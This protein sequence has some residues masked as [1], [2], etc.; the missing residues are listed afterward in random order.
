MKTTNAWFTLVE[1][2]VVLTIIFI[3]V[4]MTFANYNHYQNIAK[5]KFAAKEVSLSISESRNTAI[6][7]YQKENINQKIWVYF[8][9]GSSIIEYFSVDYNSGIIFGT[10]SKMKEKRL[11][12]GVK[13]ISDDAFIVFSSLFWTGIV[14]DKNLNV[15]STTWALVQLRYQNS[16]SELLHRTVQ[17]HVWTNTIDY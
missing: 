12:E 11:P 4:T 16:D 13:I 9:S 3:M 2:I 1:L 15:K 17:Y 7:W 6:A 5:V 10:S 14:Y 8:A